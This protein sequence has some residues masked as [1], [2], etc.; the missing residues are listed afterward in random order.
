MFGG[1]IKKY[2]SIF[3]NIESIGFEF[4][5]RELIAYRDE[6]DF[7]DIIGVEEKGTGL[8]WSNSHSP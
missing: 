1:F 5:S 7:Y 8:I 4:E 3:E 2:D 6:Y